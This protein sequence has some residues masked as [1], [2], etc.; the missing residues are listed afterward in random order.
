MKSCFI[1]FNLEIEINFYGRKQLSAGLQSQTQTHVLN[2]HPLMLGSVFIHCISSVWLVLTQ[3]SLDSSPGL[4]RRKTKPKKTKNLS[5]LLK[6]KTN[7]IAA[8]FI[9]VFVLQNLVIFP[10]TTLPYLEEYNK[11]LKILNEKVMVS[12]I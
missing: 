8:I 9:Q 6:K 12:K 10:N 2:I 1:Y 5:N 7:S 11:H 3:L 4:H